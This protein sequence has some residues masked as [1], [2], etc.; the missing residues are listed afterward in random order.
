MT[1]IGAATVAELNRLAH[2][3]YEPPTLP[4]TRTAL[5]NPL[6]QLNYLVGQLG[7][8][9]AAEQLGV[10]RATLR[11]WLAGGVPRKSSRETINRTYHEVHA[12]RAYKAR[13]KEAM[14][15]AKAAVKARQ[16]KIQISGTA[17]ISSDEEYRENFAGVIK[18]SREWWA[19]IIKAWRTNKTELV[20]Q[21]MEQAIQDETGVAVFWPYDD[22][23]LD[24]LAVD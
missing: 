15:K 18:I 6:A 13:Q 11:G 17:V 3:Y 22:V 1:T 24:V 21:L 20:G 5:K 14:R 12:P 10:T 19:A 16:R 2:H 23:T 8:A 9:G 7:G 4:T